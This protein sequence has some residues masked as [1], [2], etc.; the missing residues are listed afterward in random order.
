MEKSVA[1]HVSRATTPESVET[2]LA[3][4][5]RDLGGRTTAT[6]A[7]M[8]N[9]VVFHQESKG[10]HADLD[11]EI[12]DLR[13][14][15]V[16]RQHPCRVIILVRARPGIRHEPGAAVSILTFGTSEGGYAVEQIAICSSCNERAVPSIVRRLTLGD[17]PT[18]VWW[19]EDVSRL[20]PLDALV[21][22]G[23]QFI[24]DSREWHDVRAGFAAVAAI[25][26]RDR[27]PDLVDLNWRRLR[28][29]QQAVFHWLRRPGATRA[30]LAAIHLRHRPD[31]AA[32]AWLL[33]GWL[34]SCVPGSASP[35]LEW[36]LDEAAD[37]EAVL[38]VSLTAR[39][40][41]EVSAVMN[42]HH[43]T[44]ETPST[45]APFL[46]AIRPESAAEAVAAELRSLGR[47]LG[48]NRAVQNAHARLR[49]ASGL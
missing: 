27:R 4:L 8:S 9:L 13:I 1:T 45:P 19:A 21:D 5:W 49:E 7:I 39:G 40:R 26:G 3:S 46:V 20:P 34:T 12:R 30:D 37:V 42:D 25:A 10:A 16:A 43:V 11:D 41:E 2:E 38:S 31:E 18:S 32:L 29:M 36:T 48:L 47:D 44:L 17:L 22:L 24:Y 14:A 33:L 15:E 6:R 28:P 23:R 35:D